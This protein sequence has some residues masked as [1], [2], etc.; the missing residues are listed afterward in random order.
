M[1]LKTY[2]TELLNNQLWS[3]MEHYKSFPVFFM[4]VLLPP[5]SASPA[6][7]PSFLTPVLQWFS[8]KKGVFYLRVISLASYRLMKSVCAMTRQQTFCA[9]KRTPSQNCSQSVLGSS[10]YLVCAKKT[11]EPLQS[12]P[13]SC[14]RSV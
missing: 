14:S 4:L 8:R 6:I 3:Y 2:E 12:F 11:D 10:S 7:F 9:T 1:S 5:H 13:V